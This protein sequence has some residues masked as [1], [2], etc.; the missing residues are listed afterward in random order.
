MWENAE[1]RT[2]IRIGK[3]SKLTGVKAGTIRF[4]EKCGF[5]SP[6]KRLPNGYR[7]FGERHVYQVRVCRLV[8]GG[9]VNKRLRKIS[10]G[11]I[12]AA[13]EWDPVAYRAAAA[14]YLRAVEE[15]IEG[16][17]KAV[18][19]VTKRMEADGSGRLNSGLEQRTCGACPGGKQEE[20]GFPHAASYTKKQ[21]ASVVG[22]TPEAIRNWERNGLLG[23]TKAYQKRYYLKEAIERMY[24][25]RMLLDNGYSMMAVKRFFAA[26]DEEGAL[27]A[28][29]PLT[30]PGED[31][32][33]IY[34]ADRY[35]ETLLGT[36]EKAEELCR[37]SDKII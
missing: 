15:D 10:M 8:F 22:V 31:G 24:V 21:A 16:T 26:F 30:E 5:L 32:A 18:S 23:Q 28:V 6:V 36:R 20:N 14:D 2:E 25:I 11:L 7:V 3:L 35:L 1:A 27:S 33:L 29:C 12:A 37:L 19:V 4:Y 9:F 17:R 34:R 13:R